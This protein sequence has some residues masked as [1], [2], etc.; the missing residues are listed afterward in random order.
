MKTHME[1][2]QA[3][4]IARLRQ[5]ATLRIGVR[6][7]K[8]TNYARSGW[9]QRN[10]STFDARQVRVI[11]FE[12]ALSQLSNDEQIALVHRYRDHE[13]DIEIAQ[14]MGCSVR[15]VNYV[16]PLAR[17]KLTAALDRLDLL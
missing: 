16:L 12:R 1:P 9:A 15:K 5:W 2:D 10:Q 13:R 11:D 7:G 3:L 8:T 6:H 4:A 17:M 14:A